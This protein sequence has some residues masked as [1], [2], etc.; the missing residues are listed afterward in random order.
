MSI[1]RVKEGLQMQGVDEQI[2]YTLTTTPWGTVP[3]N[4]VVVAKDENAN[5]TDVS[6]TVLSGSASIAGNVIT[7]PVLKS[8]TEGHTYRIEVKFTSG[9]NI[10]EAYF[11]VEAEL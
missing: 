8:L 10:F 7:L 11:E 3:T 6:A 9:G 5:N 1:R 2:I 4:I